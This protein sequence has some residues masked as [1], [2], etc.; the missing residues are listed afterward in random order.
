MAGDPH[1][2]GVRPLPVPGPPPTPSVPR[3]ARFELE[4]GL[5]VLVAPRPELPQVAARLVIPSG[6]VSEPVPAFG[7]ASL[8]GSL[9]TEG[10]ERFTAVELNERLDTIGAS[11]GARVG[12]DFVEVDLV[13]LAETLGEGIELLGE[14][15]SSP[16]FPEREFERVRA[17]ALDALEARADEPANVADDRVALEVFG[18]DHPYGRLTLGNAESVASA[19]LEALVSFHAERFR[20]EGSVLVVSGA[21]EVGELRDRLTAAFASWSGH[22]EP[23]LPPRP[24]MPAAAGARIDVAWPESAQAEIRFAGIGMDRSSPD[25]IAAAV[26]NYILGGSTI[27]GRLGAN[28]REDKGWTYGVRSGFAAGVRAA[29]WSVETAVGAEVTDAAIDEIER[30]LERIV[31]EPVTEEELAR[32]REALILSLPRAFETPA[33][34]VARL[35]TVEAFGL[36]PDYWEV[37]AARVA[38]ISQEDVLRVAGRYFDPA[39]LVRVTVVEGETAG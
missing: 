39:G 6:S 9:L 28:L 2:A 32:S 20:P 33:R 35:A 12:H 26:A 19:R 5:R 15:V 37:F 13:L 25:W 3:P 36:D 14:V 31:R 4:N 21:V 8:V 22:V 16:T 1:G 30:E 10:T 17:E 23:V 27:T 18:G 29:G 11:L 34:V 24:G 38:A 7:T